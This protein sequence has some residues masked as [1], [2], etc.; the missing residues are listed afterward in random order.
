MVF[1]TDPMNEKVFNDFSL[2]SDIVHVIHDYL[3]HD[4]H[5]VYVVETSIT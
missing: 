1:K 3:L 4:L 2:E 5:F